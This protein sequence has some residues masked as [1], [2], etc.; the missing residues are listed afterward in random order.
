[1][2]TISS[3]M[4]KTFS[5]IYDFLIHSIDDGRLPTFFLFNV[6]EK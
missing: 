4:W 2:S 3:N 5:G 6:T 1:M